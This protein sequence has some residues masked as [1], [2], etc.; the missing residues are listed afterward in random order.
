MLNKGFNGL[1]FGISQFDA[2][3][4]NVFGIDVLGGLEL[5]RVSSYFAP[6]V[7]GIKSMRWNARIRLGQ[8]NKSFTFFMKFLLIREIINGME[9]L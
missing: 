5:L 3:Q 1:Y 7:R 2:K 6:Q 9:I 8:T 4:G